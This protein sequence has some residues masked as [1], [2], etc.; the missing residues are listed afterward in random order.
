MTTEMLIAASPTSPPSRG[1]EGTLS[2]TDPPDVA[3]SEALLEE[4]SD[5]IADALIVSIERNHSLAT[6][7][8]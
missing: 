1:A 5:I 6:A 3:I 7:H 2:T 4:L 8:C